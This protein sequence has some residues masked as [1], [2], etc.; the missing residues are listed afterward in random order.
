MDAERQERQ[1]KALQ[2]QLPEHV[3]SQMV[4]LSEGNP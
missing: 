1:R 2:Y 4:Y 3:S